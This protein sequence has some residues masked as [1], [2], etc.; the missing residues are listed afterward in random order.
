[1][2]KKL[3]YQCVTHFHYI[4]NNNTFLRV[5]QEAKSAFNEGVWRLRNV[6]NQEGIVGTIYYMNS[7]T[8]LMRKEETRL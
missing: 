5:R 7:P 6:Y 1:M 4:Y 8:I 3:L 2:C